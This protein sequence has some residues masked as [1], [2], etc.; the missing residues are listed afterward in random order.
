[1]YLHRSTVTA[2]TAKADELI[3][4][5]GTGNNVTG[6]LN[7]TYKNG[8]IIVNP[9]SY[10]IETYSAEKVYDGSA[11]TAGGKITGLVNGETVTFTTTG[12]Q[13]K[14]G[15]SCKGCKEC[16][17]RCYREPGSWIHSRSF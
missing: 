9:A 4:K 17:Y 8:K 11:L 1:M 15:S 7:I 14:P 16:S 12:S 13:T 5:D 10:T 6:K 3:I 2:V